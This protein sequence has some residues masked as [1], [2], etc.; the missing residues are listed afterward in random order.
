MI[1]V[2]QGHNDFGTWGI[3]VVDPANDRVSHLD[4]RSPGGSASFANPTVSNVTLPDGTPGM[5]AT[6]FVFNEG[7]A[8]GEA[9]QGIAAWHA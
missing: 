9:G 6:Y 7:S 8:P 3:H 5:V 1:E 4:V 2:Q